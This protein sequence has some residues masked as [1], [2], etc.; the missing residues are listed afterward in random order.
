HLDAPGDPV[1]YQ[2]AEVLLQRPLDDE[3][4]LLKARPAS[5][6][7]R[8]VDDALAVSGHA[9]HLLES[10]VADAHPR[11]QHHQYR[12]VHCLAPPSFVPAVPG[13]SPRGQHTT[14]GGEC[15]R[16]NGATAPASGGRTA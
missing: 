6:V 10:P 9:V 4:H 2:T 15:K 1:P 14:T 16:A 8:V 12:F 11:G 7:D 3:N 13:R 5:V